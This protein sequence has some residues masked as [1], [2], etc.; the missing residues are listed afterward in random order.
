[1]R[2]SVTGFIAQGKR[3]FLLDPSERVVTVYR[4]GT[5]RIAQLP[6]PCQEESKRVPLAVPNLTSCEVP[7]LLII[8][9]GPVI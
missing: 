9:S 5:T 2:V 8:T 7:H 4:G 3:V 1:M 6:D